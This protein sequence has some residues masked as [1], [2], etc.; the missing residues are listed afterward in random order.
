[1]KVRRGQIEAAAVHVRVFLIQS[2][3]RG[4]HYA[5]KYHEALQHRRFGCS[6]DFRIR[7]LENCEIASAIALFLSV[8]EPHAVSMFRRRRSVD[9]KTDA[10]AHPREDFGPNGNN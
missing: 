7:V 2:I 9:Y 1:M 4:T 6:R 8:G 3:R 10:P 5:A